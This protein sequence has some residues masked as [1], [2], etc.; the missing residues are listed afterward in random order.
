MAAVGVN[1]ISCRTVACRS[2]RTAAA[3]TLGYSPGSTHGVIWVLTCGYSHAGTLGIHRGTHHPRDGAQVKALTGGRG[4]SFAF[5][6]V[7]L[8]A[9][10]EQ[11][12]TAR[13]ARCRR[14][15]TRSAERGE[16]LAC[17]RCDGAPRRSNVRAEAAR[18]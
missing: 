15:E 16:L 7:G 8:A 9:T 17:R 4:A 5:E 13:P 3:P 18:L 11:V 12:R 2:A 6:A 10:H 14:T 1:P